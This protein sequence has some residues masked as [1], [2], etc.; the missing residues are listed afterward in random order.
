MPIFTEEDIL[1]FD[2]LDLPRSPTLYIKNVTTKK[3]FIML[4]P[5][6]DIH[7]GSSYCD[8]KLVKKTL[9]FI[10]ENKDTYMIGMGDY[11]ENAI[12][13]SVSDIYSQRMN[14][15]EQIM[16]ITNLFEPL[17]KKGKILGLLRGNHEIRTYRQTG[18]EPT[19]II[20]KALGVKYFGDAQFI[21]FKVNKI[22]Y[23]IYAVHGTTGAWTPGGK[24]NALLRLANVAYA[25]VYLHAHVHNLDSYARS[26]LKIDNRNKMV[27]QRKQHF[28]STGHFLNYEGSYAQRKSYP[29][30]KK[31][32]ARIKFGSR[33]WDIYVS[34]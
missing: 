25:D 33:A 8:I 6:G 16:T 21:K 22:N 3:D 34:A 15:Q 30:G 32:V 26:I 13:D 31:G 19:A 28:V 7:L 1:D 24:L 17:A 27:V 18:I 14:P 12:K 20:C 29:I 10:L 4:V 5:V 2:K 11:I 23:H 9:N